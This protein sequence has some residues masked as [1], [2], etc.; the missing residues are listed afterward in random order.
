[1][2]PLLAM[3]VVWEVTLIDLFTGAHPGLPETV[4]VL[5]LLGAPVSVT[6]VG[7]WEIHRLRVHYGLRVRDVLTP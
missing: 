6:I 2:P 4:R 1:V 5:L 3:T 7:L